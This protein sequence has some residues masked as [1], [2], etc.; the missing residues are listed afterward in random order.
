MRV[1]G[2]EGPKH[3]FQGPLELQILTMQSQMARPALSHGGRNL[4]SSM[5]VWGQDTECS[6]FVHQ[7]WHLGAGIP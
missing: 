3:C 4:K 6:N 1:E 5:W 2:Q 7:R